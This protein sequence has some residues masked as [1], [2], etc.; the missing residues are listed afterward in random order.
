MVGILMIKAFLRFW[1]K[2]DLEN[3]RALRRECRQY[4]PKQGREL[5]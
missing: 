4:L 3:W 5:A 1:F 2:R